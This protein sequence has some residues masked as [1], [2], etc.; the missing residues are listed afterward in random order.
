[1]DYQEVVE[2]LY[3]RGSKGK[4]PA[5]SSTEEALEKLGNPEKDYSVIIVGGTNGKGSVTEMISEGLQSLGCS[6]GIY[7]SPHLVSPRER[8]KVDGDMISR[9]EFLEI[10]RELDSLDTSLSFFEFM[11]AMA[12]R[13]FQGKVDYAV[14]EVGMGGRL[15]ATNA[16]DNDYAFI[17]NV[18][19][20]HTRYLGDTKEEIAEEISGITPQKGSLVT[21]VELEPIARKARE[22][23]TELLEPA[24]VSEEEDGYNFRGEV[25]SLPVSGS[26]QRSNLEKALKALETIEKIPDNLDEV[27]KGLDCAGRMETISENP[28]YIQDGAH[29]PHAIQKIIQDLPEDFICVFN[30]MEHKDIEK[31]VEPL[32]EKASKFYLPEARVPW[33]A[34]PQKIAGKVSTPSEIVKDPG[35][36]TKEA[37]EEAGDEGA[38]VVTGSLYLIGNVKEGLD[39]ET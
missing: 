26:Y 12:Y 19:L 36:A 17:T 10:Y 31:M 11:T 35:R 32:E 14:M 37:L 30:A 23:N 27:F 33:S 34:R 21:G 4:D 9:E 28:L 5:L 38:V 3:S 20:E 2:D 24:K 16:A 7:K 1:M 13:F 6:V 18:G 29:N 39:R 25:F 22:R 8:I 15:D